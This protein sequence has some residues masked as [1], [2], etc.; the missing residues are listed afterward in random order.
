MIGAPMAPNWVQYH[1]ETGDYGVEVQRH[2]SA[3]EL[4]EDESPTYF[5]YE[6]QGPDALAV[7]EE[8]NEGPLPETSSSTSTSWASPATT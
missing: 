8:V 6:V 3:L 7:V 1:A 5:R 2:G 4:G